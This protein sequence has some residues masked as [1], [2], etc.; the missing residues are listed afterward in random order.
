[1]DIVDM[2]ADAAKLAQQ[3]HPWDREAREK[4]QRAIVELCFRVNDAAIEKA[5]AMH[6]AMLST[7]MTEVK[8]KLGEALLETFSVGKNEG[9]KIEEF[10]RTALQFASFHRERCQ[11]SERCTVS[12]AALQRLAEATGVKFSEEEEKAFQ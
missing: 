11:G 8:I 10:K 7:R 4:L 12:L 5:A 6:D 1:M 9:K 2:E 3:M